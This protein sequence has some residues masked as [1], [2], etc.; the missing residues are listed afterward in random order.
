MTSIYNY[1]MA[2]HD[3]CGTV[4]EYLVR[5]DVVSGVVFAYVHN[6]YPVSWMDLGVDLGNRLMR[7]AE[8]TTE[9]DAFLWML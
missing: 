6:E 7:G 3:Y 5:E 1:Y 8:P 2:K 9:E 4:T